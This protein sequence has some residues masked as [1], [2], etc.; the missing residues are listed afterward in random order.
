RRKGSSA[1]MSPRSGSLQSTKQRRSRDS[2]AM[3]G[4]LPL[5]PVGLRPGMTERVGGRARLRSGSRIQ[6]RHGATVLRPAGDVV[7][8]RD[9]ALFAVGDGADAGGRDAARGQ[10]VAHGLSAARAEREVVLPRAAL[11]RV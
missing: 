6:R 4:P 3:L 2:I 9:G 7:A 10:V 5:R 8:D 11:V 1:R